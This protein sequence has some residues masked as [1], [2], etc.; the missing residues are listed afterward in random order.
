MNQHGKS[1]FE[2]WKATVLLPIFSLDWVFKP[3]L[4]ADGEEKEIE[5]RDRLEILLV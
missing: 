1:T 3:V 2:R 5:H 4:N